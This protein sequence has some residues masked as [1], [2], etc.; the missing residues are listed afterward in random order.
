MPTIIKEDTERTWYLVKEWQTVAGLKARIHQCVWNE[1]VTKL[2]PSMHSFY[3]GYVQVPAGTK[4]EEEKIAVHGGITFSLGK[5]L[6]LDGEWIGF[7]LM[8]LGDENNQDV[9]YVISE[10]ESLAAQIV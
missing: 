7:D 1:R 6:E 10:C 2:A 9:N 4:L 3:C 8:H 5:F